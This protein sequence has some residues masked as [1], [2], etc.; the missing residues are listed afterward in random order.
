MTFSEKVR[1]QRYLHVL[2]CRNTKCDITCQK[3]HFHLVFVQIVCVHSVFVKTAY[4][5]L[6]F[7]VLVLHHEMVTFNSKTRFSSIFVSF[8]EISNYLLF[9]PCF[10]VITRKMCI[11]SEKQS[12]CTVSERLVHVM[13][14]Y[15]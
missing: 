9:S 12:I 11:W 14:F 15:A 1:K 10:G 2:G 8:R 6:F 13:S 3:R 4:F 7:D 5:S